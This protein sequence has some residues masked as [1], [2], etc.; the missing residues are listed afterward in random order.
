MNAIKCNLCPHNCLLQEGQIGL[1]QAR[2]NK[3]GNIFAENYGRVTS[4]ALDPIEKKPLYHFY[5][6]SKILSVGSYGCNLSCPFC[7]NHHI[8]TANSKSAA[9][10]E[11]VPQQLVQ[12]ATEY[13]AKGNIGLAFTYNEPLVGYEYVL[14]CAKLAKEANLKVAVVTNGCFYTERLE[15]LWPV[16]DAFNIDLKGFTPAFYEKVGGDLEIV[17]QFIMRAAADSH[18]EVTTLI[19]P[20]Q[21]DSNEEMRQLST[22][23]AS[24]NQRIPLHISRF[25]PRYKMA[26]KNPT[27]VEKIIEL[28][29]IAQEK[30]EFVYR[31][32]C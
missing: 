21:N 29:Q 16:V 1:C 23:L 3:A 14:Q 4:V 11:L 32:N 13:V 22:W 26:D 17:K 15:E 27:D 8:S 28:Q 25:F 31:G 30:L 18:V 9:Y 20:G 6:A 7:Q 12:T 10:T 24:V 2:S 5:P 19:I